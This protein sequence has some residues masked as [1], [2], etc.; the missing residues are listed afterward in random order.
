MILN[1]WRSLPWGFRS[2]SGQGLGGPSSSLTQIRIPRELGGGGHTAAEKRNA[3]QAQRRLARPP[4][5]LQACSTR[6]CWQRPTLC[7][8]CR[9]Q[10]GLPW[11]QYLF[12]YPLSNSIREPIS[13]AW[14]SGPAAF[15]GAGL[16]K[17][18]HHGFHAGPLPSQHLW[19]E[20]H[21]LRTTGIL[22]IDT[23]KNSPAGALYPVGPGPAWREQ[24]RPGTPL[25]EGGTEGGETERKWR[26]QSEWS[27]QNFRPGDPKQTVRHI[28]LLSLLPG[29]K[30]ALHHVVY[31]PRL[32]FRTPGR[33]FLFLFCFFFN[34]TKLFICPLK[35]SNNSR[36]SP[37]SQ[38]KGTE[39]ALSFLFS[40]QN[41]W[42]L[43]PLKVWKAAFFF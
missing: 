20:K 10:T 5:F 2:V 35:E 32:V 40:S 41:H 15:P 23:D 34:Y 25:G 31:Q 12:R 19:R 36:P 9:T 30:A 24:A 39:R 1:V 22:Q 4:R 17:L 26:K 43:A 3:S 37:S 7:R 11:W 27:K 18:C 42:F 29:N 6:A 16:W 8:R 28:C 21:S 33:V 38:L 13:S 14:P